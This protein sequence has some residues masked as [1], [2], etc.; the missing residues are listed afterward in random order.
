MLDPA[1]RLSVYQTSKF[2]LW[3]LAETLRLELHDDGIDVSV[4]FPSGMI[5]RHLET[6]EAA[7]PDHLRRPVRQPGDYEAM[8]ASNPAMIQAVIQGLSHSE[9]AS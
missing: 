8:V 3:G 4:V 9:N 2:A 6:S 7:Q 1:S 5:S